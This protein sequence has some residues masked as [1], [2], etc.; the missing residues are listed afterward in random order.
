MLTL[1]QLFV[2]IALHY[3]KTNG[4]LG[5]HSACYDASGYY[6]DKTGIPGLAISSGVASKIATVYTLGMALPIRPVPVSQLI[7]KMVRATPS[8]DSKTHG[9]WHGFDYST[10]STP[11]LVKEQ[12]VSNVSAFILGLLN[13]GSQRMEQF[14]V[15]YGFKNKLKPL[16]AKSPS[17]G[18][19]TSSSWGPFGAT[20]V[21]S[22]VPFAFSHSAT[23]SGL[24]GL[25]FS[26]PSTI[27][28]SGRVL[29]L[30][31]TTYQPSGTL[32]IELKSSSSS[33]AQ[34]LIVSGIAVDSGGKIEIDL[35][36]TPALQ[37]IKEA[38]V[39]ADGVGK[40]TIITIK[41]FQ[42]K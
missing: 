2:D 33:N 26:H 37:E 36:L 22:T 7:C 16:F 17:T 31:Y 42:F 35:P 18:T 13:N 15:S 27:N 25:S 9:L 14:A 28:V 39:L 4:Q 5:F 19:L 41:K 3:S 21:N 23:S 10:G 29:E 12:L 8:I 6:K 38:L 30:E 40:S 20:K 1:H 24:I 32:K 34:R 11:K